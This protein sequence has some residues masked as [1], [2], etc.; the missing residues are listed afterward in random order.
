M[1]KKSDKGKGGGGADSGQAANRTVTVNKGA[2]TS[3]NTGSRT[4]TVAKGTGASGS[5]SGSGSNNRGT[6]NKSVTISKSSGKMTYG[7]ASAPVDSKVTV[8]KGP[9]DFFSAGKSFV[10][11]VRN[12]FGSGPSA[13]RLVT[14]PK[15]GKTYKEPEYKAGTFKG[16]TSTDPANVARNREAAARYA[17]MERERQLADNR[18]GDRST[19]ASPVAPPVAP[20]AVPEAPPPLTSEQLANI[21]APTTPANAPVE[22]ETPSYGI[23][24]LVSPTPEGQM[25]PAAPMPGY[26]Q[27][28]TTPYNPYL[29][30]SSM[31]IFGAGQGSPYM[32]IFGVPLNYGQ[33]T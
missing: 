15:T 25:P 21:G 32:D 5:G 3:T 10:N 6:Q 11:S 31:D 8:N 18:R 28:F 9:T 19:S 2:G 20:P 14:D 12:T 27:A 23:A 13:G 16:L 24:S 4:V 30:M 7:P 17:A 33:T 26:G 1:S 22:I 29:D